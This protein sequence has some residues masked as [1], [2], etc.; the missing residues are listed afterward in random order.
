MAGILVEF[1]KNVLDYFM[2][3]SETG[4]PVGHI[5]NFICRILFILPTYYVYKK[6]KTKKGMT[7]AL[8]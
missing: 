8:L 5:A 1:F 2:T 7:F 6:L 3:G 4:V